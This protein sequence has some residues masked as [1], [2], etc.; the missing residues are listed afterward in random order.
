[1]MISWG[2]SPLGLLSADE[3]DEMFEREEQVEIAKAKAKAKAARRH[4]QQRSNRQKTV[5]VPAD[6]PSGDV[7]RKRPDV[8]KKPD[9]L[10][11]H[12]WVQHHKKN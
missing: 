8:P 12:A 6:K 5:E 7:P 4:P 10:R 2:F 9:H 11:P 1:M 3:Y